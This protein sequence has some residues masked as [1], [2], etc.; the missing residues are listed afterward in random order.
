[1]KILLIQHLNF[2]N[3]SGGTEKICSFLANGFKQNKHEVEIATNQN[4]S[5][6]PVFQLDPAIKITNIFSPNILQKELKPIYN[7]KGKNPFFWLKHKIAKKST[8]N[9]NKALL[10]EMSG[11]EELYKFNLS[12]RAKAWGT[13]ILEAKPDVIITMSIG[14][15][16]EI[17]YNNQLTIPI[18]NSVNGR[19][20]YDYTDILWYRSKTEMSLLQESYKNLSA[21]QV[22]FESYVDYLPAT[23]SGKS[24]VV[25]NPVFQIGDDE[26]VLHSNNKER[27][28]IINIA[29]LVASCK[30]QDIAI[31]VFSKLAEKYPN[32]DLYFWGTGNDNAMLQ[33]QIDQ[34]NL[35]N[36]IFLMGFTDDPIGKLKDADV[37]IFPSKY[38]GFPLALSE[39]MS[40][41]L[42]CLGF[43]SCSGVNELIENE[44]TGLLSN[45]S[46]E[47]QNHLERLITDSDLRA[48]LGKT[49]HEFMK[50]FTSEF[51]LD[52]WL[53]LLHD[54]TKQN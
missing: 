38:E 48:L 31:S 27:Y 29:S 14:S 18:I 15:L 47:M 51:V 30:Q 49:S 25:P 9:F 2:I 20:D 26:I 28:K 3:G 19:P 1:M 34:L 40:V 43:Q 53:D 41:G 8:K 22:L 6:K 16:L 36:R 54:V 45:D 50:K 12:Q 35:Q 37:F 44:A 46:S 7:Y 21:I 24:Y 10:R 42:P 13:Y 17:T 4:I 33:N 39:A 32:W 5:G 23:F 52:K 11:E